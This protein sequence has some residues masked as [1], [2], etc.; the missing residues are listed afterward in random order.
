VERLPHLRRDEL[1]V[2][3]HG[4]PQEINPAN[5]ETEYLSLSQ[6]SARAKQH[7]RPQ[8]FGRR[9]RYGPAAQAADPMRLGGALT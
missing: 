4:A 9:Y 5:R 1:P 7:S 8:P 6:A 2:D 3:S